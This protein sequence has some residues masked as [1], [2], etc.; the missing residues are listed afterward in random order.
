MRLSWLY[1]VRSEAS[2]LVSRTRAS[3]VCVLTGVSDVEVDEVGGDVV[4]RGVGDVDAWRGG[5]VGA[6]V[7]GDGVVGQDGGRVAEVVPGV[8]V[9]RVRRAELV[10]TGH[11]QHRNRVFPRRLRQES[12]WESLLLEF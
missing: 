6:G 1:L 9:V 4:D 2:V 11:A 5:G 7:V 3:V 10:E 8:R 12:M